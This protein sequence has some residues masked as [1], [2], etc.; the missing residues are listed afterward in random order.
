VPFSIWLH[1]GTDLYFRRVFMREKL[2]YADNI[3]TCCDFN[4]KYIARE[5]GDIAAQLAPKIHV[6]H[7]GLDLAS[8]AFNPVNRPA[9][10]VLAVGRFAKDKGYD[11]LV[12]AVHLVVARGGDI[13]LELIGQGPE[14][15]NL[16]ALAAQL[17]LDDRVRFRGWLPFPEVRR[18]MSEATVLVHPST[19]LGDGLPNVIREAMAVGTPVIAS[20][21]AGIPDALQDGCGVLVPPRD[22]A[23][24]AT[25]ITRLL[26]DPAQRIE[27]ASR[28]RRRVE[29]RYDLWRNGARLAQVLQSTHRPSGRHSVPVLTGDSTTTGQRYDRIALDLMLGTSARAVDPVELDWSALRQAGQRGNA[30]VRVADAVRQPGE[31]LPALFADA[32]AQAC[33]RTQQIVELVDQLSDACT[34]LGLAHAFV[35]TAECYPDAP[36][37]IDLLIGEPSPRVD[38]AITRDVHAM[39]RAGSLHHRLAGVSTYGLPYGNRL[40]IRHGR[41]GRLGEHARFAR[42]LLAR[43]RPR[44]MGTATPLAPSA[45]DHILLLATHQVFTRP[46]FRVSDLH[47]AIAAVRD[48]A[49]DWDYLFATALS[50]ATVAAVGCYLRYLDHVN[51]VVGGGALVPDSVL[52]RFTSGAPDSGSGLAPDARFPRLSSAARLYM[53]S[54]G[55]TLESGR[56]HSAARLSLVP[57]LAAVSAGNRRPA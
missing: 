53:H 37:A 25:A 30:L 40:L 34:R 32:T 36:Q 52:N 45:A 22:V 14:Q 43:A 46:K 9:N 10:R 35:R 2:L 3:I 19:G 18:A 41:V 24:L 12:R 38:R 33:R 16:A 54:L 20:D 8:F 42:L 27:I 50:T 28:A 13:V 7:H 1:A 44:A 51:H 31:K 5:F 15:R 23:A 55:A 11:D 4:V 48:P 56:W 39:R 17:G 47:T 57:L 26:D 49:M 21:V 6:N 29:E